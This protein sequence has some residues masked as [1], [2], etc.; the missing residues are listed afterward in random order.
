MK[1]IFIFFALMVIGALGVYF[2]KSNLNES[3]IVVAE[4]VAP[5]VTQTTISQEKG[6][7]DVVPIQKTKKNPQM[8]PRKTKE[9]ISYFIVFS[10]VIEPTLFQVVIQSI[11]PKTNSPEYRD[12]LVSCT[13]RT[14]VELSRWSGLMIEEPAVR[15]D[16]VLAESQPLLGA[17][18]Y[19]VVCKK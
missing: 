2:F 8:I 4:S 11:D 13:S 18:V 19:D 9:S 14:H 6:A 12:W 5:K 10:R 16:R 7:R 1:R 15:M 17:D 3:E